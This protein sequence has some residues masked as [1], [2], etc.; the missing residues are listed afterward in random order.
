MREA[1]RQQTASEAKESQQE[2]LEHQWSTCMITQELLATPV[3]ADCMGFL[4]NKAA[5]LEYLLP[6]DDPDVEQL[7]FDQSKLLGGRVK[8]MRDVVELRLQE[9]ED[10]DAKRRWVC[11]ISNKELGAS[12]RSSYIVPC[13]HVFADV[14]LK[15]VSDEKCLQC[16]EPYAAENVISI[17]PT[18][19][20]DRERLRARMDAL[21]ERGLTHSLKKASSK[22]RKGQTVEK[23]VASSTATAAE[24]D[25]DRAEV[26][27]RNGN[28]S[29]G[30]KASIN[31]AGTASLTARVLAEEEAKAKRR[32]LDPN[33]NLKT[34]FSSSGDKTPT[35]N[36]D[37]MTRGFRIPAGAKR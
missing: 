31:N 10:K 19:I 26:R 20:A 3:V 34:L 24:G 33:D 35:K 9:E 1:A 5:I 25:A 8:T 27:G 15:A 4:Y 17:L 21:R 12:V 32:K 16:N 11:P 29:T 28:G 7:K 18:S 22:K 6:S 2:Q 37:F 30:L 36:G 13:G 23:E 14:A